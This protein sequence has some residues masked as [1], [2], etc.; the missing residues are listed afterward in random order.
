M[1]RKMDT[2]KNYTDQELAEMAKAN[3][4]MDSYQAEIAIEDAKRISIVKNG[5][6]TKYGFSP[7][8]AR[9]VARMIELQ[10]SMDSVRFA[11]PAMKDAAVAAYNYYW[12]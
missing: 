5:L 12:E 2:F 10:Q 3:Q 8:G 4:E 11:T 6:V 1:I 9:V 7:E